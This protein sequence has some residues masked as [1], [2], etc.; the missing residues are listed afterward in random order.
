M[1]SGFWGVACGNLGWFQ[2][3]FGVVYAALSSWCRCYSVLGLWCLGVGFIYLLCFAGVMGL[4]PVGLE[5]SGGL[6]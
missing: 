1:F 2:S 4:C 6:L 5:T 3:G